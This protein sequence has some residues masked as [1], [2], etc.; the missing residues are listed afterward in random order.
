[1]HRF[2]A[3]KSL[4]GLSK[5]KQNEKKTKHQTLSL[6]YA[7]VELLTNI[8]SFILISFEKC[9][10]LLSFNYFLHHQISFLIFFS[11]F[12]FLFFQTTTQ[13]QNQTKFKPNINQ[14][15]TVF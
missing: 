7:S 6:I 11:S 13:K 15:Y 9:R 10:C 1:M 2:F 8:N 4:F 3:N 12:E 5:P 14:N